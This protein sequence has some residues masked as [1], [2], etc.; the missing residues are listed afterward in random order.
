MRQV[1]AIITAD[2]HLRESSPIS[3]TDDYWKAQAKKIE[4]LKELQQEH[5]CPVLDAGD[6]FDQW[7]PSPRLLAW[8]IENLPADMITVPGNHDMP[9]HNIDLL[10]KSGLAVLKAADTISILSGG[11]RLAASSFYVFGYAWRDKVPQK[12]PGIKGYK[13]AII[14]DMVYMKHEG[15]PVPATPAGILLDHF[16]GYDLIITG[17]NHTPFV[18]EDNGRLVVNPGS[19]MRMDADQA[20]HK[21]RCYLWNAKEN[22]VKP[23]Y[24]PI[25][26]GVVSRDHI[27][28]KK[29]RDKRL[30]AFVESIDNMKSLDLDFEGNL[31][32]FMAEEKTNDD[33]RKVV[34]ECMEAE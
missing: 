23:V 15:W 25:E 22:K 6:L 7:K 10:H 12:A 20:D 31:E 32:A 8:A 4:F 28:D 18:H 9:Q 16:P 1:D 27:D 21:P 2:I 24:F 30:D 33:V 17:H 29:N 34:Y 14:H 19:M 26:K 3:R 5:D 11:E 13:V